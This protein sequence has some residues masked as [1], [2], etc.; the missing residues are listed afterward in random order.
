MLPAGCAGAAGTILGPRGTAPAVGV[1]AVWVPP[2]LGR[3]CCTG[4]V[5][6]AAGRCT[7]WEESSLLLPS[8]AGLGLASGR[9]CAV[10]GCMGGCMLGSG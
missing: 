9:C 1:G 10:W 2:E 8:S 3:C 7:S 4:V 6:G 5:L